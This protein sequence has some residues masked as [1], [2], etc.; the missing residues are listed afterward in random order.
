VA[1]LAL[2]F[3]AV[4]KAVYAAVGG[5]NAFGQALRAGALGPNVAA[6][7]WGVKLIGD[8]LARL[9]EAQARAKKSAPFGPVDVRA[10]TAEEFQRSL[11]RSALTASFGQGAQAGPE[12]ETA[13]NTRTAA[14]VLQEIRDTLAE[15]LGGVGDY[16]RRVGGRA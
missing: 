16:L 10:T 2:G 6:F 15:K 11:T 12:E 9:E 14:E 7:A 5:M 3:T 4:A 8:Q 13:D 1:G